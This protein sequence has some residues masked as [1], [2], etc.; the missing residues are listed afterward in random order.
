[1][2]RWCTEREVASFNYL[3]A[4]ISIILIQL[5]TWRLSNKTH[6]PA[7]PSC[8]YHPL[9]LKH[10]VPLQ[11]CTL[12]LQSEPKGPPFQKCP[13][14]AFRIQ[15]L[16]LKKSQEHKH[17]PWPTCKRYFN[18]VKLISAPW[19]ELNSRL[20]RSNLLIQNRMGEKSSELC[21]FS[22]TR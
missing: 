5:F 8:P 7:P 19:N 11:S 20:V 18:D 15:L 22:V 16:G 21:R 1:M 9:N 17:T 6:S 12:K 10:S 3:S 14:F 13:H 4:V 2:Q